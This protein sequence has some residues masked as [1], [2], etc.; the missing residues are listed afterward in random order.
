VKSKVGANIKA[1]PMRVVHADLTDGGSSQFA[2]ECP[3]CDGGLLLVRRNDQYELMNVDRCLLCG[4][5]VIYT[6]A[7]IAGFPVV[8]VTDAK[9]LS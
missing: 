6:D 5:V 8:D 7:S 2:K 4:Q 3:A 1:P 9:R